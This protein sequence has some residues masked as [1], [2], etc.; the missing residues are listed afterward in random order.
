MHSVAVV[1]LVFRD[2]GRVL[3]IQRRDTSEWQPPGGV[4]ELAETFEEGVRRGQRGPDVGR[5]RPQN[6]PAEPTLRACRSD[7]SLG[8][9]R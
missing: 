4:L 6:R 9:H 1:G 3:A 5:G 8:G 7:R 2:D